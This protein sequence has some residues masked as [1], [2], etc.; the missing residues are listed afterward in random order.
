MRHRLAHRKLG[1]TSSHRLALLRNLSIALIK[2]NKIETSVFKA[3]ELKSYFEKLV[4]KA[5]KGDANAH[6]LVF[7]SLQDKEATKKLIDTIAVNLKERNGGYVSIKRTR[8]RRGDASELAYVE[9][10]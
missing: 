2:Y 8:V 6:R 7:A 9:I 1:R 5:K 3:K 4:T 10:L